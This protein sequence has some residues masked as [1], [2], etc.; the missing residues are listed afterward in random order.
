MNMQTLNAIFIIGFRDLT[1]LLRDKVRI[2][3]GLA[4]PVIF[5]GILGGSLSANIGGRLGFDFLAFIFTG[6]FAQT[7]FQSSAAGVI[8]L[9]QDRENDFSQELFVAPVPRVAIILGKIIGE[10]LVAGI[11]AL[12]VL[13][14]G[15]V[16]GV[17]LSLPILARM[18]PAGI[19]A[20]LLG[21]AFG[22]LVLGN[23]STQRTV[24]QIFP[25]ILFPQ[26]FLAGVFAP[27]T[28]APAALQA[29]ARITPLTYAVNLV[30]AAYYA[31]SPAFDTVISVPPA[32]TALVFAVLF[33]VFLS[34]GTWLF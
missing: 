26:I 24:G 22:I 14:F 30:R 5:I 19:A 31:D 10:T 32:L 1:K 28:N 21:G 3:A 33:F 8:S 34:T 17:P 2:F 18:I 4:F 15:L 13:I 23:I 29:L 27:L 11:A 25:F 16:I 6:V 7:F 9:V 12:G 20:S